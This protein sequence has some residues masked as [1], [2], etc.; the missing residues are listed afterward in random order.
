M[1][2]NDITGD[3]IKTKAANNNFR[4]NFDRIFNGHG[5]STATEKP[6]IL[7]GGYSARQMENLINQHVEEN[8]KK[9]HELLT[10]VMMILKVH[11]NLRTSV[12][13]GVYIAIDEYMR[14]KKPELYKTLSFED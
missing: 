12:L 5:A 3:D 11:S 13:L 9:P 14:M 1:S 4:D 2:K 10:R 7:G 6:E 8:L